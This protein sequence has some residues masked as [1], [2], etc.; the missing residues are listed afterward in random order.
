VFIIEIN[1]GDNDTLAALI[2][3]TIDTDKL[4]IFTDVD[5]FYRGNPAMSA[6]IP[7]FDKITEDIES[8]ATSGSSSGKGT[9][10]V[11]TKITLQ[12]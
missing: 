10:G 4:I 7:K 6:L 3:A 2:A 5:D 1:F 12:G 9:E 11:K 8:Y